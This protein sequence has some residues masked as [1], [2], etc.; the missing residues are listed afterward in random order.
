M[1]P[2]TRQKKTASKKRIVSQ[3]SVDLLLALASL[4]V[5]IFI[6]EFAVRLLPPPY[7]AG[8]GSPPLFNDQADNILVCNNKLGWSG[9]PNFQG[10]VEV[11]EFRT[12]LAF[13]SL[14]LHDTEHLP[15]KAPDTFRILMLGDS[16]IHAGQVDEAATAHQVLEDY[17]N[18][19][20]MANPI[21]F[22]V[23]SS[24]VNGWGTTQQLLYYREQGRRF[25]PDLVLLMFFLG[26]DFEDN[27][28]GHPLT[29]QGVNCYAPY[30]TLCDGQLNPDPVTYAPGIS[31]PQHS[32]SS[33]QRLLINAV[34]A[35]Y[36]H[37][38]LYRQLEPLIQVYRPRRPF[39]TVYPNPF[40]ALYVPNDEVELEHAWQITQ[41][42]ITQLKQEV[43]ADGAQFAVAFFPWS[44]IIQL[45]LLPPTEQE[46]LLKENPTLVGIELDRPNRRMADFLGRQNIPFVDL[47]TPM[48]EYQ[49]GQDIPL[50]FVGDSHWTVEGNR[51]V[52]EILA[53]WFAQS[54]LI[55]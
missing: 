44:V 19:R 10:V 29:I 3:L 2:I 35:F 54:N 40:W 24:G 18:Q 13:N 53:Y 52:A 47:T 33:I 16:F 31:N 12:D 51:A 34:G 15:E 26:N 23:L 9:A 45:S 4:C 39:G 46:A 37:S 50:H 30:F 38:H 11:S 41:A 14:G 20:K 5:T 55:P 27:L 22:E 6:L 7:N 28:P 49:A 21:Q 17:L 36:Q 42:T 32:C 43:E 1:K 8:E 48:I 25:Q